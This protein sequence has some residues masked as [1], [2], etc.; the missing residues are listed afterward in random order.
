[1]TSVHTHGII[2]RRII[3]PGR[4]ALAIVLAMLGGLNVLFLVGFVASPEMMMYLGIPGFII[5]AAAIIMLFVQMSNIQIDN[6]GITQTLR[7]YIKHWSLLGQTKRYRYAWHDLVSYKDDETWRRYKG[8]RR[9][10]RFTLSDGRKIEVFEGDDHA[11]FDQFRE[12]FLRLTDRYFEPEA[13]NTQPRIK[14]MYNYE[15]A[16]I[17]THK[18]RLI[19]EPGFYQTIWARLLALL[20]AGLTLALAIIIIV[21]YLEGSSTAMATVDRVFR[22]MFVMVPGTVYMLFRTFARA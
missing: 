16:Y 10:L 14:A 15:Q 20:F 13:P 6:Y 7:P 2:T 3:A 17:P 22:V 4:K 12:T 1:M 18:P 5:V 8:P 9:F 21:F 19:K 11:A